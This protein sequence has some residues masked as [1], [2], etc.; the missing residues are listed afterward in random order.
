MA[1]QVAPLIPPDQS[2]IASLE[3]TRLLLSTAKPFVVTPKHLKNIDVYLQLL[4]EEVHH[5]AA[6]KRAQRILQDVFDSSKRLFLLC[7]LATNLTFLGTIRTHDG[8]WSLIEWWKKIPHLPALDSILNNYGDVF[9][10]KKGEQHHHSSRLRADFQ[11]SGT[12]S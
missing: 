8:H 7:A 10:A 12:S 3:Q 5:N 2:I 11:I 1:S 4:S 9:E 6:K